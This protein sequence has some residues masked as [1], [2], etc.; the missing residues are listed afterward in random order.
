MTLLTPKMTFST[1]KFDIQKTTVYMVKGCAWFTPLTRGDHM[2]LDGIVPFMTVEMFI[3]AGDDLF[4]FPFVGFYAASL[5]SASLSSI[6]SLLN[7]MAMLTITDILPILGFSFE[8]KNGEKVEIDD[9]NTENEEKMGFSSFS[10]LHTEKLSDNTE[11]CSICDGSESTLKLTESEKSKNTK[12]SENSKNSKNAS[13]ANKMWWSRVAIIATS[14]LI[15]GTSLFVAWLSTIQINSYTVLVIFSS[16]A[17]PFNTIVLLAT[18]PFF[19]G[20][21]KKSVKIGIILGLTT[22]IYFLSMGMFIDPIP[23][24]LKGVVNQYLPMEIGCTA[25]FSWNAIFVG[26][27]IHV[28]FW[29]KKVI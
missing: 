4:G 19:G 22:S 24:R 12:N 21:G 8:A 26:G 20:H 25:W 10:P 15:T 18:L 16:L 17:A 29:L 14:V 7:A 23:G 3:A 11:K 6:S 1:K 27:G 2:S 5:Y 13:D 9:K 28:F